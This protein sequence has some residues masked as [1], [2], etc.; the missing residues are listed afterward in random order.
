MPG[1]YAGT[2]RPL[3]F[4]CSKCKLRRDR[5]GNARAGA[6]RITGRDRLAP[7]GNKCRRTSYWRFEYVC[8]DCGH[9]GWSRHIEAERQFVRAGYVLP[10]RK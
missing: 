1:T 6:P 7:R 5:Y 9:V 10:E 3:T 2:G 8:L 4:K